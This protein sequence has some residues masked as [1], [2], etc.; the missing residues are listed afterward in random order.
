MKEIIMP[1]IRFLFRIACKVTE[2]IY[3]NQI[4]IF[5]RERERVCFQSFKAASLPF[6]NK[7]KITSKLN[8]FENADC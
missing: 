1:W 4:S 2:S 7:L 3:L 6:Y 5:K 8:I